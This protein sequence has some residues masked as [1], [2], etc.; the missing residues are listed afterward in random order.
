MR[1]VAAFFALFLIFG[2]CSTQTSESVGEQSVKTPEIEIKKEKQLV[3]VELFT[4]E[5]CSSCPPA[6][7]VLAR[8]ETGQPVEGVEIVPLALHV[9]Y[10]NHL[11]WRDEFSSAAF[12]QRQTGYAGKFNLDS[13]YTPQMIVDGD[14]QFVGS[15][16]EAALDA[17]RKSARTQKAAVNLSIEKDNLNI[18]IKDLPAREQSTVWLAITESDLHT[19]VRR[20]ENSGK[21]L[22]HAAV[23]RDLKMIG[24]LAAGERDFEKSEKI[25]IQPA[26]KNENVNLIVFV[27]GQNSKNVFAVG[28]IKLI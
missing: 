11:G 12:S 5:G 4:S 14:T 21:K 23:A 24:N 2:N 3:L 17:V 10:W 8:L 22:S 15:N 9:D 25:T 26:W 6:D 18:K 28:K 20:G 7:K 1:F 13:I 27:Q 19:N 16:F